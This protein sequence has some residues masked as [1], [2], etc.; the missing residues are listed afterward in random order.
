VSPSEITAEQYR[1]FVGVAWSNSFRQDGISYINMAIGLNSNDIATLVAKQEKKITEMERKY[2]SL[3][4]RLI[5]LENGTNY[6]ADTDGVDFTENIPSEGP[7]KEMT[8]EEK[9]AASMPKPSEITDEKMK[10]VIAYLEFE[11]NRRGIDIAN[12]PGLHRLFTDM[13]FQSEVIKKALV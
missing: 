13:D 5:A 1:K 12:H 6:I 9:L 10:E 3:E 7:A 11:Y 2:K 8:R 4:E